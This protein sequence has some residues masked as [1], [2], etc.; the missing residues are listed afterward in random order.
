MVAPVCGVS[1]RSGTKRRLFSSCVGV[2]IVAGVAL[3]AIFRV[4][5]REL[6]LLESAL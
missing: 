1:R 5:D 3:S 2:A 6:D 4:G